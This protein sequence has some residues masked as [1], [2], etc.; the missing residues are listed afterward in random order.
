[1]SVPSLLQAQERDL[2]SRLQLFARGVVDGLTIGQHR[3]PHKGFSAE[4]KEHRPYVQGDEIRSIDWKLYGKTD[5]L[6]IRQ[7]EEET[8]LRC[9]ILV[10]QSGSMGYRGQSAEYSKHQYAVRLAAALAY[11]L[12]MQRDSVGLGLVDHEL[13]QFLPP[14]SNPSHLQNLMRALVASSCRTDTRLSEVLTQLA[15][16]IRRRGLLVLISDC[17]D[18]VSALVKSLSFYRLDHSEVVV[19]QIF[20]RD[21]LE[22]PFRRRVE[23]LDLEK[24]GTRKW[25]DPAALRKAYLERVDRF[26]RE[27]EQQTARHRIDL[28]PCVTDQP[29]GEVLARYLGSRERP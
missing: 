10:D 29:H 12:M 6:F 15:P 11:L 17:F 27:L 21:E 13:Q 2:V 8:N 23:F 16:R 7:F 5:R 14:R 19:F 22:F 26:Q 1:M 4:F 18:D 25:I 3:S 9:T 20:D 24:P 28:V